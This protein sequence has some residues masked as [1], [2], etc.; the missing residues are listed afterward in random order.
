MKS[1]KLEP[2]KLCEHEDYNT[3]RC[4]NCDTIFHSIVIFEDWDFYDAIPR[5][6][7]N[8]RIMFIN[9]GKPL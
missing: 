5:Y 1:G 8:C 4:P 6:C 9:G 3:Y 7:P 2:I